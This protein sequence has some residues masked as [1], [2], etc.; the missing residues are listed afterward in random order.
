MYR[1]LVFEDFADKVGQGFAIALDDD[2]GG[3]IVAI[4]AEA[5]QRKPGRARDGSR[6]PFSLV[7]VA[8]HQQVL[9][10]RLYRIEHEALGTLAIFLVPI[11]RDARGVSYQATF[12]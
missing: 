9:P 10:Q 4:L 3:A 11:A 8:E 6:A 12:N 1:T 5:E 2:G 7:F